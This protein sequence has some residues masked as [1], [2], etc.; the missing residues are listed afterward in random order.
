MNFNNVLIG[1]ETPDRLIEYYTKVFGAPTFAGSGYANWAI[2]NGSINVGAHSEVHG[3]STHP[4]RIIMNIESDDVKGD[5][6]RLTTNGAIV[7]REAYEFEF[8]GTTGAW[9]ATFADPDDNYF[10]LVSPMSFD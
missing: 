8:E 3:K 9:I 4:G 7:V 5:A 1:S 2:G 6:A 10:Q